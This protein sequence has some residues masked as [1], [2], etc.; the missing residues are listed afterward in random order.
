MAAISFA[1]VLA[2]L[3]AGAGLAC[4]IAISAIVFGAWWEDCQNHRI[5]DHDR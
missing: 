1:A 2:L 4:G 5:E 3:S